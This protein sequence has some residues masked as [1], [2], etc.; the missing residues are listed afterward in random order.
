METNGARKA[1]RSDFK[2]VF[3]SRNRRVRGLWQRNGIFYAQLSL[4]GGKGAARIRLQDTD[5]HDPQTVPQA[6]AAMQ[7]LL[8]KRRAGDLLP[9]TKSA[10]TLERAA[11]DYFE[12][13]EALKV[14]RPG[15]IARERSCMKRWNAF[16]GGMLVGQINDDH[17]AE[18]ALQC[19][20]AGLAGRSIDIAM[21]AIRNVLK[22]CKRKG[23]LRT[24]PFSDWEPMAADA[25]KVR[26]VTKEEVDRLCSTALTK[27]RN[28]RNEAPCW[29]GQN[30]ADYLRLLA[31]TG[32][33]ETETLHLRWANVDFDLKQIELGR[34]AVFN[35]DDPNV[36]K[37]ASSRIIPMSAPLLE[38][39]Q[40]MARRKRES[41]LGLL[42]P[43]P[44]GGGVVT[45]YKKSLASVKEETK[46]EDFGFHHLRHYFISHAVM[47]GIDYKTIAEWVGHR[48]GGVLIG[49]IYSHL[50]D[51]HS[52]SQAARLKFS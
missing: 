23:Y 4:P 15:S 36:A 22:R 38:H 11:K 34:R 24:V 25:A 2:K 5:Q 21:V 52:Q 30:F 42:F 28:Y 16:I 10:P 26:L 39:L 27:V 29:E 49:R 40:A 9:S 14:K 18:F 37:N 32:G 1:T 35:R 3:D 8:S 41:K 43:S 33:R 31:L 46:I 44:R 48:D 20:A 7:E 19:K 51:S 17:V 13:Q 6:V 45:S 50:N 12:E 47:S